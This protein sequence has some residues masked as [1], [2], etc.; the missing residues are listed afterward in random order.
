LWRQSCGRRYLLRHGGRG[1]GRRFCRSRDRGC[2]WGGY[3]NHNLSCGWRCSLHDRFD[4]SEHRLRHRCHRRFD[5][6]RRHEPGNSHLSSRGCRDRGTRWFAGDAGSLLSRCDRIDATGI[7]LVTT[8]R[9]TTTAA[10]AA[11]RTTFPRFA[12]FTI[13][14]GR[15]DRRIDDRT[16]CNL[17]NLDLLGTIPWR[18]RLALSTRLARLPRFTRLTRRTCV[19][20]HAFRTSGGG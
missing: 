7:A 12:Q 6:H 13:S 16:R 2:Y 15:F 17:R 11:A 9:A 18:T 10:T 19:Q 20:R 5:R 4:R 8:L 14:I 3:R 1:N